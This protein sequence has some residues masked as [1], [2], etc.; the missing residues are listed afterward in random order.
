MRSPIA[1]LLWIRAFEGSRS[2]LRERLSSDGEV[3]IQQAEMRI[4]RWICGIRIS[5]VICADGL[6]VGRSGDLG[7]LGTAHERKL[8]AQ[9]SSPNECFEHQ[10]E[11]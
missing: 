4:L 7:V 8:V 5:T 9:Q 6:D 3:L 1:G 10:A 11:R 2:R